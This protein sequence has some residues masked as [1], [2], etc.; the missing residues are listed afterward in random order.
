VRPRFLVVRSGG[1]PFPAELVPDLEIVDRS[2][3]EIVPLDPDP[4]LLEGRY[5]I[6]IVTSRTAV[7]RLAELENLRSLVAGRWI[8]VGPA[9]ADLLRAIVGSAV[10][11]GGGSA[12]RVLERLPPRL[13]GSRVLLPRGEDANEELA[14]EI[15]RRGGDV[16]RLLLYRKV[17]RRYDSALDA[18]I[19]GTGIASFCPT[20]P[21]ATRWLFDGASREAAAT[22]R[23]TVAVALGNSTRDELLLQGATHVEVV[24][25]PTFESAARRAAALAG[26]GAGA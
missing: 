24:D 11:D 20:S 10:E 26:A 1:R 23:R 9:T 2:S 18:L 14:D 3:H 4:E 8:A 6:A 17:P 12:R 22:L 13:E 15:G 5:D 7:E 25:P 19:T 16:V 21:A